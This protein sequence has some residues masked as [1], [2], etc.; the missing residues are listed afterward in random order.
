VIVCDKGNERGIKNGTVGFPAK[1]HRLL[2]VI[3]AMFR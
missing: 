3:E 2:A 1:H